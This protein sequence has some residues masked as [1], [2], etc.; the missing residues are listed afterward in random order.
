MKEETTPDENKEQ[1]SDNKDVSQFIGEN[2][3]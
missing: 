3:T 2:S 1:V